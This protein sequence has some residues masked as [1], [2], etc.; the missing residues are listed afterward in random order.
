MK[1]L[2]EILFENYRNDDN[3][4]YLLPL[5]DNDILHAMELAAVEAL[6]EYIMKHTG[7]ASK[8]EAEQAARLFLENELF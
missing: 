3:G 4:I 1:D 8:F 7:C 2:K 6:S 5:S